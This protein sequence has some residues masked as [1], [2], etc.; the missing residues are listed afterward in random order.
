MSTLESAI[1]AL[2][3]LVTEATTILIL[4]P[5]KP[6]TDSLTA[7][8]ALEQIFGDMG[9][10]VI[11]YSQ[12][13]VPRYLAYFEGADRV[14]DIFPDH[15][16]VS[17]IVDTG[18]AQQLART[19]EKYQGRIIKKPIAIID[20]HPNREPMPFPTMDVIDPHATSTAEVLVTIA[21]QLGWTINKE[22]ASLMVPGILADTRN[23]SIATV[24]SGT[25]RTVADLIDLGANM[26]EIHEAYRASDR[27]T[28]ELVNLKGRLLSR[29][30]LHSNGKIALVVVTPEELKHYAEMHDPADLVIYDMQNTLG[31]AVAVVMRHYGGQNNKIKI[32]TRA[33]MPVAAK[34]CKAFGGGGHDRAA[35]CQVNDTPISEVKPAFITELTK[36]IQDYEALQHAN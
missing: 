5:E 23:L 32:S 3:A 36:Q 4:Q 14:H 20:H 6:D 9:K 33:S 34:A 7:S 1:T 24:G 21:K 27:L 10:E 17:I 13:A 16:D 29:M 12:D 15:F 8:L 35:G 26:Y 22:A 2:D 30:E 18:G 31:V 28:P 11:M 25:F 19:L